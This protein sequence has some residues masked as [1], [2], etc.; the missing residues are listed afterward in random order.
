MVRPLPQGGVSCIRIA[1]QG[2]VCGEAARF[3]KTVIVGDVTTYLNYILYDSQ[4]K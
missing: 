4:A 2:C 3:Q 1:R